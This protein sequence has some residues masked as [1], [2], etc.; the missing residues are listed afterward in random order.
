M[1]AS[2]PI[3]AAPEKNRKEANKPNIVSISNSIN[4][5]KQYKLEVFLGDDIF[6]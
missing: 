6:G 2:E 3:E 1:W 5:D 4:V